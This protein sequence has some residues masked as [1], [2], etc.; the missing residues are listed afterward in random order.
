MFWDR[1]Q[2]LRTLEREYGRAGVPIFMFRLGAVDA[3]RLA[4]YREL[5][6]DPPSLHSALF[7]P[8]PDE[9]I[10]TGVVAMTAAVLDLM[11]PAK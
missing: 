5:K 10:S 6:V 1:Q 7:Y 8:D 11:A 2:E 3:K 9:T 4:R